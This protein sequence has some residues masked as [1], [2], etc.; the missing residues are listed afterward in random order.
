MPIGMSV[1]VND[2]SS[3][4]QVTMSSVASASLAVIDHVVV[5][6]IYATGG[7]CEG[8]LISGISSATATTSTDAESSMVFVPSD[9]V[10]VSVRPVSRVV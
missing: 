10:T 3:H 8:L 1:L 6:P 7:E 2:P 9:T 5:S 4:S